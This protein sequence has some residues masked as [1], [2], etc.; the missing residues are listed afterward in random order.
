MFQ[1]VTRRAT[2][3][4]LT[5]RMNGTIMRRNARFQVL[6]PDCRRAAL[7][8]APRSPPDRSSAE[9]APRSPPTAFVPGR[10]SGLRPR[11]HHFSPRDRHRR[12]RIRTPCVFRSHF[13]DP[14]KFLRPPASSCVSS[15]E[16]SRQLAEPR[17]IGG[18]AE[19]ANRPR[20]TSSAPAPL[21]GT[22]PFADAGELPNDDGRG[23]AAR[24]GGCPEWRRKRRTWSFMSCG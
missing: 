11:Q 4:V 10:L 12:P 8:R 18:A 13:G 5:R 19:R 7:N 15:P 3:H 21:A 17:R 22:V 23:G 14:V 6:W 16:L 1:S 9:P 2:L 24:R 20:P